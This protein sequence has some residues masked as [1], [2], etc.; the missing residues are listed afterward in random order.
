MAEEYDRLV[1]PLTEQLKL[2]DRWHE[3]SSPVLRVVEMNR[4]VLDGVT[5]FDTMLAHRLSVLTEPY[6]PLLDNMMTI[7]SMMG[8]RFS[9]LVHPQIYLPG[10][11]S[12]VAQVGQAAGIAQLGQSVTGVATAAVQLA[13]TAQVA[14][15][16]QTELGVIS[17]FE[18]PGLSDTRFGHLVEM[19]R[20]VA[21]LSRVM[22]HYDQMTSISAQIA[23][24]QQI[25]LTDSWKRAITPPDLLLG[26]NDFALKQYENIQRAS[27]DQTIAWRLGLIDAASKYVD[28]QVAWGAEL[29]VESNED[30][31]D[32]EIIAPD[33]SELPILLAYS[34][35]DKSDVEEAFDESQLVEITGIGRVIIQKARVV[36][37]FCKANNHPPIFP[38]DDLLNWAMVLSGTFCRDLDALS[39]VMDNLYSMFVRKPVLDLIGHQRCFDDIDEYRATTERRKRKITRIQKQIYYQIIGI[40]DEIIRSFETAPG[41]LFDEES[42]SSN[43]MRA[44]LNIQGNRI[45]KGKNENA[46][47]DGIRDA[48]RMVYEVRDQTRQGDS[49]S[50][51]DSGEIDILLCEKGNPIAILEGLKLDA[52]NRDSLAAHINK[53]LTNYDPIGCPLIYVLIYATVK[54]FHSFWEKVMEYMIEYDFPYEIVDGTREISTAYT[55]SRHAK[56]VLKRNGKCVSLHLYAVAMA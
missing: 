6:Q 41:V 7:E 16:W 29:A 52:V 5:R 26:L 8:T 15:P 3:I 17:A 38:T 10:I 2:Y 43:I 21:G 4:D 54:K 32:V 28:A 53:A 24:L 40:E 31:P 51:K 46:I 47:N 12:A 55:D 30:A 42:I 33:F 20:A 11:A 27:D 56:A 25:G 18:T 22:D 19:E 36:N 44:L 9:E 34:K 1:S 23:S 35:R 14:R 48:L 13:Q 37:D 50:G 49:A 45:Y 39:E